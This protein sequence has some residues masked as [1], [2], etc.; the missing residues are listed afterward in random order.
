[1][2]GIIDYKA[3]FFHNLGLQMMCVQDESGSTKQKISSH[4]S[5]MIFFS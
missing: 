5:F 4:E 1:M 3:C 2:I